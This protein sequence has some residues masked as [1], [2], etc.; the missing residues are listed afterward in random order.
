MEEK[1]RIEN[2]QEKKKQRDTQK[3]GKA[4]QQ[5]QQQKKEQEKK[6]ALESITRWR[7]GLFFISSKRKKRNLQ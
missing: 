4:V 6:Q 5:I 7:K 1:R 2:I 3:Y